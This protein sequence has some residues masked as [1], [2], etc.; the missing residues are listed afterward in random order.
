MDGANAHNRSGPPRGERLDSWKEIAAYLRR[1]VTTVQRW[2]KREGMPVHRH[3]HDRTGSVYAFREELDAWVRSRSAA[4]VPAGEAAAAAAPDAVARPRRR[5]LLLSAA[6]A[7]LAAVAAVLLLRECGARDDGPL[8]GARFQRLT[9]FDGVEQAV[10]YVPSSDAL[11]R[12]I[13]AVAKRVFRALQMRGFGRI[14]LRLTDAAKLVVVE[15]NP[16]PEIAS[17]EDLAEAAAKMGMPYPDLIDRI[18]TL[19]LDRSD[20]KGI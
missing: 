13:A 8:E 1:D 16:N 20:P 6:T 18:V 9:D 7:L 5:G 4:A 12:S 17:G 10:F 19:G 2:E 15:A 3:Q 11:Q 14:D